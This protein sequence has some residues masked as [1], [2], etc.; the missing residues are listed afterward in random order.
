M[1]LI[2]SEAVKVKIELRL[3]LSLLLIAGCALAAMG[4]LA[5]TPPIYIPGEVIEAAHTVAGLNPMEIMSLVAIL[6]LVLCAYLI[7]LL[8]GRLLNALDHNTHA[9]AE[10]ARL[11]AERPCIRRPEND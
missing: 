5:A 11:L 9:N 4:V 10:L 7:R 8:F 1:S 3:A 2:V 6:A